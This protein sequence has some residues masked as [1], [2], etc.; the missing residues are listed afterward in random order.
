MRTAL[1]K[2]SIVTKY[3]PTKNP[4]H[5]ENRQPFLQLTSNPLFRH[6]TLFAGNTA[7][8]IMPT[9]KQLQANR[10][11]AQ[12]STGP[13]TEE[14]KAKSFLNAVKTRLTG[15]TVLLPDDD[16]AAYR[17]HLAC[18]EDCHKPAND[19]E[20]MLVQSFADTE[21]RIARIPSLEAGIYAIGRMELGAQFAHEED[22]A[23]RR[24]LTDAKVFLTYQRQL[25]NLSIQEA[26][27][28]RQRE[29]DLAELKRVQ[30]KRAF[31]P[32]EILR[33]FTHPSAH[34]PATSPT[35]TKPFGFDF[36]TRFRLNARATPPAAFG[37]SIQSFGDLFDSETSGESAPASEELAPLD[38]LPR[39]DAA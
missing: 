33:P 10:E 34:A 22:A 9:D 5:N 39:P 14:G 36:S 27:L 19:T 25:N 4:S 7:K 24:I 11:N 38:T 26:R 18:L 32:R 21:W 30:A 2:N 15:R 8:E 23:V 12:R 17:E 31:Q 35:S 3:T 16:V 1:C 6:A 28:R 29:E 20:N 37:P 13:R